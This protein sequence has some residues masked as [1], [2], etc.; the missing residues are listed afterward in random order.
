MFEQLAFYLEPLKDTQSLKI[1]MKLNQE[2][3]QESLALSVLAQH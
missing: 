2:Q 1:K 3:V